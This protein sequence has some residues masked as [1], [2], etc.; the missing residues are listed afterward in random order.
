MNIMLRGKIEAA[1]ITMGFI[2]VQIAIET[3]LEIS[4]NRRKLGVISSSNT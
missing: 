1:K 3:V 2:S 4:T